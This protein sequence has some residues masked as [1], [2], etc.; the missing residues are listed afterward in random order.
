[1]LRRI[2]H[3]N[4]LLGPVSDEERASVICEV[5]RTALDRR[6]PL[7]EHYASWLAFDVMSRADLA[8]LDRQLAL[9]VA[10]CVTGVRGVRAFRQFP[11]RRLQQLGLPSLV[12]AWDVARH[13]GRHVG[14]QS[15]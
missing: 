12:R 15:A 5:V 4:Q 13:A 11:P 2:R 1:L 10:E 9:H 14:R 6:A 3:T 7:S 8:Q